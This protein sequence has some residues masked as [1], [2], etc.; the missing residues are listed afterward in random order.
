MPIGSVNCE[1]FF[2]Q[3]ANILAPLILLSPAIF[4]LNNTL[5]KSAKELPKVQVLADVGRLTN[6]DL[7]Q[8]SP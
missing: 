5:K 3:S 2:L 4:A 7:L 1:A 8:S 6:I